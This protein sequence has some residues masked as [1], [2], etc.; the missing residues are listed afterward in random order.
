MG[1]GLGVAIMGQVF[2]SHLASGLADAAGGNAHPAFIGSIMSTLWYN[3]IVLACVAASAY[4][5]AKPSFG[6][7][8]VAQ[9]APAD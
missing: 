2:F 8:P 3:I 4:L 6:H 5:L 7:H 9:P 1:G